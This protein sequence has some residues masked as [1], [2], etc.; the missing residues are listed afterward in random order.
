MGFIRQQEKRLA[1]RLLIW[2][3]Q[4]MNMSVPAMEALEQQA[5]RFVEDAHRIA[6]ERGRNVMSILKEMIG[7]LK[8][9]K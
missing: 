4:R 5:A 3:Y 7:D 6:R 9:K 2:Q 1:V 8:Q